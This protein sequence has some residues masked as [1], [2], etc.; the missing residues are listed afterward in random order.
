MDKAHFK[1]KIPNWAIAL[2]TMLIFSG[3]NAQMVRNFAQRTSLTANGNIVLTGNTVLTCPASAA[4]TGIQGGNASLANDQINMSYVDID[5]DATTFNSS[6][7][8]LNMPTGSTVIWAGLY[9]GG[10][11]GAAARNT[12]SFRTPSAATYSVLTATQLDVSTVAGVPDN[13]QGFVNVTANVVAAGNG[14]YTVAN[15]QTTTGTNAACPAGGCYG[16]W[17]L[18]VLYTNPTE[19]ARNLVVYDGFGNINSTTNPNQAIN[20]TGF[21]TPPSGAVDTQVGV[22][23][24]EGDLSIAGDS[25]NINGIALSD[26]LNPNGNMFNSSITSSGTRISTKN[27]DYADQLGI[28]V[29]EVKSAALGNN[30]TNATINLATTQ[31]TY[32]PGVVTFST[33]V[34][35]A[36]LTGG[37][38]KTATDVNGGFLEPNDD[39]LY[40]IQ[41]TDTGKDTTSNIILRDVIPA[42]TT[43]VPGSLN[44]TSGANA[45]AKTDAA[46]DDQAEFD[47]ANNRVVFRVGTGATAAVGG[48]LVPAATS[49]IAFKARVNAGT[50]N[51][52]V[53]SNQATSTYT[54]ALSGLADA[55]SST[56]AN[57]TVNWQSV[58]QAN[59]SGTTT[60]PESI[61][62]SHLYR[63][64]TLGTVALSATGSWSY[65]VYRDAN[66]DGTI[67]SAERV[68][69]TSFVVDAT[70]PREIDGRLK[71]CTLE[72]LVNVPSGLPIG[73]TDLA[74]ISATLTLAGSSVT[75]TKNVVDTTKISRTG[76]LSLSKQVRNITQASAFANSAGGKP[77]DI[78]EYC[79]TYRNM[80]TNPISN[81]IVSDPVPFFTDYVVNNLRLNGT[82]LTDAT[83]ADAGE[84]ANLVVKVRVGAVASGA[85]GQVCYRAKIR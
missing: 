39:I 46:G 22:I 47:I 50:A 60:S 44:I 18:V 16:G 2:L 12:I 68:P 55:T 58:L 36:S 37:L 85:S 38:N 45:G 74:N 31:D 27:P 8:N 53:V 42:N 56:I 59:Q 80:G 41:V 11:S 30:A 78:L 71:A 9:W 61:L 23:A 77:N 32:F 48:T 13:Y 63:P 57:L 29:D 1:N 3:A 25:F 10:R 72:V 82:L 7:A 24:Y 73:T 33:Q 69:V 66:C 65:I 35:S 49:Y 15:V 84:V 54:S 40:T 17:G 79:I 52:M 62:Y 51:G 20:I 43:Y 70:W 28:D 4:C 14:T 75:D 64:G 34:Y 5:G 67:S 81:V 19:L 6:S 26:T 76:E 21:Q 83:D